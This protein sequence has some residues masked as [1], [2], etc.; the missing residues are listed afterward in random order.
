M[1]AAHSADNRIPQSQPNTAA[2]ITEDSEYL[3]P[4]SVFLFYK[5]DNSD[6]KRWLLCPKSQ[7]KEAGEIPDD[8]QSPGFFL[9]EQEHQL[10]RD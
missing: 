3:P 2:H 6:L 10:P 1:G 5:R 8:F 4:G 7:T 9:L